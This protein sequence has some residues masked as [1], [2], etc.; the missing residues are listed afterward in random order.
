MKQFI[1]THQQVLLSLREREN[2]LAL[3]ADLLAEVE[4]NLEHIH[5]AI[6]ELRRLCASGDSSPV[7]IDFINEV[8]ELLEGN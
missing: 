5:S 8:E 2:G 7:T 6:D 4:G 3:H 1:S